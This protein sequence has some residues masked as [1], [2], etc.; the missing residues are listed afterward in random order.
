MESELLADPPSVYGDLI[1]SDLWDII[2][3]LTGTVV[4]LAALG[5]GVWGLRRIQRDRVI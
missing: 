2:R 4:W 5:A 3:S 1:S